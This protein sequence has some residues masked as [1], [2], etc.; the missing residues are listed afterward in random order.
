MTTALFVCV[1]LLAV[2]NILTVLGVEA[3]LSRVAEINR[4]LHE[5]LNTVEA[6]VDGFARELDDL[7]STAA[8]KVTVS[9]LTGR[10]SSLE[11][12]VKT[13]NSRWEDNV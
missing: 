10:L 8:S 3:A 2:A 7:E 6:I 5:D 1:A 4:Y 12:L 9:H 13:M 11:T